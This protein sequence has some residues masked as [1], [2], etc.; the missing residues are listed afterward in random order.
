M[1]WAE[2]IKAALISIPKILDLVRDG[3]ASLNALVTAMQNAREQERR[4]EQN[5]A[6]LQ[7]LKLQVDADRAEMARR[8][9]ALEQRH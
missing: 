9:S 6:V 5:F 4:N 7:T 2:A 1:G 3:F 8:L